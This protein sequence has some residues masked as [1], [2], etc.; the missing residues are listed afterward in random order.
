MRRLTLVVVLALALIASLVWLAEASPSLQWALGRVVQASH[1]RLHF[2]GVRGSLFG[3]V[4]IAHARFSSRSS[5]SALK[6]PAFSLLPLLLGQGGDRPR[7][8]RICDAAA[9]ASDDH[10]G[11]DRPDLAVG[12][13]LRSLEVRRL[14][15][16]GVNR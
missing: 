5:R 6:S 15:V 4:E 8:C 2:E 16:S 3:A 14:S 13:Q 7:G 12:N 9:D 11:T 1:G 10:C